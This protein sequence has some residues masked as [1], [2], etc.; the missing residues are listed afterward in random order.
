MS[1]SVQ[2]ISGPLP[3][4]HSDLHPGAG[5][6]IVVD[7]PGRDVAA[8][9]GVAVAGVGLGGVRGHCVPAVVERL[10]ALFEGIVEEHF[11]VGHFPIMPCMHVAHA[12]C[13][14]NPCA[15]SILM[16]R[17]PVVLMIRQPPL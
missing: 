15:A 8:G 14:E 3:S 17:V 5:A 10:H 13:A 7:G 12:P 1:V 16:I 9:A 4:A 11:D 6:V 2:I